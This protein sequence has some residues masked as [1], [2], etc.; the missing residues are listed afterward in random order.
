V[1][2]HVDISKLKFTKRDDRQLQKLQFIAALMDAS[3]NFITGKE[4]AMELAL[5]EDTFTRLS[6]SGMNAA[7]TL[8][9]IPGPYR[10]RV[11]VQDADGKLTALNQAVEI[12]K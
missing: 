3:G 4:G 10:V 5:K 11:V 2:I 7:L 8:S 1:N 12:P 6:A 9:A